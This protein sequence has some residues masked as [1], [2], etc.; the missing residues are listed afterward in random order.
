MRGAIVAALALA[1]CGVPQ[2]TNDEVDA[3]PGADAAA[4]I[5]VHE[6]SERMGVDLAVEDLP[7]VRWFEGPC[8]DYGDDGGLRCTTGGFAQHP[9]G[10][11]EIHVVARSPLH[12]S[13]LAHE[14]LHWALDQANGDDDHD[15]LGPMWATVVDVERVLLA[16]G[17]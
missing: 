17:L 15:H 6:W 14:V 3:P 13:K 1:A 16:A 7:L 5:V 11:P 4:A 10:E 9:Y 8:L 12:E 2:P